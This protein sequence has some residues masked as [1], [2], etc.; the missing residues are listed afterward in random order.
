MASEDHDFEEINYFNFKGRNIEWKRES[1]GAVGELS[2]EGMEDLI[3]EI[4]ISFGNSSTAS[5]L[6][7]LFEKA[8]QN[9]STLADATRYIA[10]K[11]FS[12][13]GL[14]IVDGNDEVLKEEFIPYAEMEFSE[15]RSFNDVEETT[16]RLEELGYKKQVHPRE[17]NLFYLKDG[18]RER[19]IERK[20]KYHVNN[21]PME[22]TNDEIIDELHRYP[23]RFSPNALLR[24]LYQEVILPNICYIGGGGELA[25]W[26]QLRDY[27]E[28]V[29][30]PFPILLLRNSLL[31]VT[32]RQNQ[33]LD[34]LKA[35]IEWLFNNRHELENKYTQKI[36]G[37]E[38]DL[39]PQRGFLEQQFKDL[40]DLAGKTDRSFIGAVAAQEKK[41]LNGLDKL[42][43]RL[44]KAEKRRLKDEIG[45]LISLQ[46][47]LFPGGSLQERKMNFS[48]FYID[49]GD[50]LL[51]ILKDS[52]EPLNDG[53]LIL[54]L[55]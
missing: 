19:I 31:L 13:F 37:I 24:P 9:N 8:Y 35:N 48:E 34:K 51:E 45:R 43:K 17:I 32:K 15:R 26:L 23:T 27:F 12:R 33:K 10:N 3:D 28:N 25:Y 40:Y 55:P 4:R 11:L 44:L 29:K 42:E 36:S 46:E 39:S 54:E 38:I 7:K 21:T 2:T 18:I 14:V 20:G 53:F 41:Q 49:Y 50:E 1:K 16:G 22:F 30:V 6:N 47:Q 52:I 5:F